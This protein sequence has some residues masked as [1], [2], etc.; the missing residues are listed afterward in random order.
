MDDD[1]VDRSRARDEA[2]I[3][4]LEA[5]YDAAWNAADLAALTASFMPDATIIDPFGGVSFGRAAIARLL[6]PLLAGSGRG[7]THAST[8]HGVSFVSGDVALVDGEAVIEGL[9][10]AEA[11][12][13]P[14]V[15]HR[16]TDVLVAQGG[17]WRIAQVR[18]YVFMDGPRPSSEPAIDERDHQG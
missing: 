13:M 7:S 10:D 11:N 8:V 12:V 9:R 4:S 3:R 15:V 16:F 17:G 6:A 14:T 5:A 18:A 2:A 1:R